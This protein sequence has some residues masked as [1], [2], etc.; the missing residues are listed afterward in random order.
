MSEQFVQHNFSIIFSLLR[1]SEALRS[2]HFS[3]ENPSDTSQK[4]SQIEKRIKHLSVQPLKRKC[5]SFDCSK[6]FT[7]KEI[8]ETRAHIWGKLE[9]LIDRELYIR[10]LL[11]L[12]QQS[13]SSDVFSS[14]L[15]TDSSFSSDSSFEGLSSPTP[16]D[17]TYYGTDERSF[18]SL[19]EVNEPLF[20]LQSSS[21]SVNF[22]SPTDKMTS[23]TSYT[24]STSAGS[25][26]SC[27][28]SLSPT[29]LSRSVSFHEAV[30]IVQRSPDEL[31][32]CSNSS[33]S[34]LNLSSQFNRRSQ[35]FVFTRGTLFREY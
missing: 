22:N 3:L 23:T 15:E 10:A 17:W 12:P 31:F 9:T 29:N 7:L 4:L 14:V 28:A 5:C 32:E 16:W 19:T 2:S 8:S 35:S 33:S 18:D 25:P 1:Q 26:R 20:G 27:S 34:E 30:T 21:E 6:N 11:G 13:S 24:R